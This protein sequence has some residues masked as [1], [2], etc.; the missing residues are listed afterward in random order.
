[1]EV[2]IFMD[3]GSYK[4]VL[5]NKYCKTCKHKDLEEV[6]DPCNECLEY[7]MREGTEKPLYFEEDK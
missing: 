2:I 6:K 1:M 4:D 5:F 3:E 7:G